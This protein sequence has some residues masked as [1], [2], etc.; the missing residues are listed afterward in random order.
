M[1]D[2]VY[3]GLRDK[4]VILSNKLARILSRAKLNN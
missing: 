4:P 3:L 1:L 2:N